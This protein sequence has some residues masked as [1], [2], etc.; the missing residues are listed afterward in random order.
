ER[1]GNVDMAQFV[2]T[3][4]VLY[5]VNLGIDLSKMTPLSRFVSEL[6]G[7]RFGPTQPITGE[8][9]FAHKLDGHVQLVQKDPRLIE[10]LNPEAVGNQRRYPIGKHSGPYVVRRKLEDIGCEADP[11]QLDQIVREV[12]RRAAVVHRALNDGE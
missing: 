3:M 12:H 2:T 8:N 7:L 11:L 5:G 4:Q 9:A 1:S 6:A 10:G